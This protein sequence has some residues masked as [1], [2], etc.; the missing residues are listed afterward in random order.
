MFVRRLLFDYDGLNRSSYLFQFGF[1]KPEKCRLVCTQKYSSENAKKKTYFQRLMKGIILNYHQHWIVDN[2]PVTLCN[3]NAAGAEI[4][5]RGFPIGCYVSK[6]GRSKQTCSIQNGKNDTFYVFNH[7][8]L[9][10]VYHSGEGETWGQAFGENGG[11][12]IAAK[13][14]V[15]R[16]VGASV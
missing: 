12:I 14:K 7:V 16:F 1:L 15:K 5:S 2:M 11:R 6:T 9:E 10:I 3:T 8:E 13:V 4:C